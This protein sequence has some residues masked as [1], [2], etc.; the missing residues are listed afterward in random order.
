M[1]NNNG[2]PSYFSP[3]ELRV[4]ELLTRGYSI[5]EIA[6]KLCLSEH[7]VDNHIRHVKE[8]NGLTKNTEIII[9]Y[10][11][12]LKGKR[13]SLSVLREIGL[14]AFLILVNICSYTGTGM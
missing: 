3:A 1:K 8:K 4:V 6:D 9:L 12:Y 10:I 14:S 13:F 7:T 5:K 2:N 11:S